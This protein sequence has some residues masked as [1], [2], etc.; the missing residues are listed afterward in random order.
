MNQLLGIRNDEE[1]KHGF[2]VEETQNGVAQ[3]MYEYGKKVGKWT[4]K[5]P[6]KMQNIFK[7]IIR[8]EGEFQGKH[9]VGEWIIYNH[10]E[11]LQYIGY[12]DDK[13]CRTGDWMVCHN[14]QSE[15][16]IRRT[17]KRGQV[18]NEKKIERLQISTIQIKT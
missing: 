12:Y 16:Y 14:Q 5:Y 13:N 3:G 2:T 15:T 7:L 11:D 17:Y 8:E 6:D 1:M 18:T 10:I 4:I 9:K